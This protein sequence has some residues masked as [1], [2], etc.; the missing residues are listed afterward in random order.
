MTSLLGDT[1][2]PTLGKGPVVARA[3][4]LPVTGLASY[5]GSDASCS[6]RAH[7]SRAAVG[8]AALRLGT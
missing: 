5:F 3:S 6:F 1:E 8:G 7:P 4:R 2:V